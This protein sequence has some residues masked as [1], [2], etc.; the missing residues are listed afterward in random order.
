MTTTITE[1]LE[2]IEENDVKFIRLAFTDLFGTQKNI[3]IMPEELPHAFR[4]GISFDAHAIKGFTDITHSDLFLFPD[5]STLVILPWRPQS[6][7]VV[8]FYCDIRNEDGTDFWGDTRNILKQAVKALKEEGYSC[9]IG[10]ECEFYLFKRDDDGNPTDIPFDQGG[11]LDVA[12][13]DKGENVRREICL[14]LEEMGIRPESSHHEQGPGQNE[15]DFKFSDPLTCAD[16]LIT[17]KHVVKTTAARNGLYASFSPKPLEHAP[18]NGMHIN[19]SLEKGGVNMF[20]SG[21]EH[22]TQSEQFIAG[23]LN[24][25]KEMSAVL[26]PL[27]TSYGRFGEMEAPKYVSWSHGNRSQLI[28]IPYADGDR[29]RMELRSPDPS[30]NPYLA[31]ALLIHAGT[32]GIENKEALPESINVD[33]YHADRALCDSLESLPHSL[34]EA[35]SLLETSCFV[36]EVLSDEIL[37]HFI[38]QK[39]TDLRSVKD[40]LNQH[41]YFLTHDFLHI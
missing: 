13:L 34:E 37:H 40:A 23:I 1:I 27:T 17:F 41:L 6:G 30:S 26:N 5:P 11:Y 18:G 19:L 3:S 35:L 16:H 20:K 28:R 33:L 4:H 10:A 2:F 21:N 39:H 14:T 29:M 9:R 8:R 15:I 25:T 38:E 24:R 12:P 36:K 7:R 22:H 31:F 32:A